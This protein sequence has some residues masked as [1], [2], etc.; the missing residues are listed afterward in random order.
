MYLVLWGSCFLTTVLSIRR[1][2]VMEKRNP[3]LFLAL[4]GALVFTLLAVRPVAAYAGVSGTVVDGKTNQGWEYG[5][6]VAA[7]QISISFGPL[8]SAML[9]QDGNFQLTYDDDP[10]GICGGGGCVAPANGAQIVLVVNFRCDLNT[11]NGWRDLAAVPPSTDSN[12][13]AEQT[14]GGDLVPL[15]GLPGGISYFYF[16]VEDNTG[17]HTAGNLATNTGPLAITLR[18]FNTSGGGGMPILL[19]ATIFLLVGGASL[20]AVRRRR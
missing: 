12:C 6:E 15:E 3:A 2:T 16:E 7:Y 1:F 13:P 20:V 8:G 10:L 4:L 19:F 14:L 11:A 5:A 17:M 9:D 18:S